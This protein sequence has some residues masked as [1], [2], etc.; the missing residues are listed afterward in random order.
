MVKNVRRYTRWRVSD[1]ANNLLQTVY[2]LMQY[3]SNDQ[4]N[5]LAGQLGTSSK[6][7]R[8]WFQN[9][10][11]R[12]KLHE[13]KTATDALSSPL[14]GSTHIR[15]C[16]FESFFVFVAQRLG[17]PDVTLSTNV[18]CLINFMML[19]P[20]C[21]LSVDLPLHSLLWFGLMHPECV[22]ACMPCL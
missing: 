14:V 17:H 19:P 18:L 15:P 16:E 8:V 22:A 13:Q 10:R 9:R 20:S 3:P 5:R 1:E 11:Q 12:T 7:I 6:R 21:V 2:M 4:M